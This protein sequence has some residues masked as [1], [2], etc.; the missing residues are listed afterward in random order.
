MADTT[1]VVQPLTPGAAN[2]LVV[3]G[4]DTPELSVL[5]R[6]PAGAR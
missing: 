5:E 2:I 1:T 6:L 4:A 3:A